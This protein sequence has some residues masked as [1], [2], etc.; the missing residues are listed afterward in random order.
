[1]RSLL[2]LGKPGVVVDLVTW[3][4]WC[5]RMR[6]D[7]QACEGPASEVFPL[8]NASILYSTA[9]I[10]DLL[11][12]HLRGEKKSV[13]QLIELAV[14]CLK[15]KRIGSF[16]TSSRQNLYMLIFTIS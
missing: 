10:E 4:K 15:A 2:F 13:R 7:I 8:L 11:L 9:A 12:F 6:E 3:N 14:N 16:M 1:M 5:D